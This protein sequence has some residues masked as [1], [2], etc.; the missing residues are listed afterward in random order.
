MAT[1]NTKIVRRSHALLGSPWGPG[2]A[3]TEAMATGSGPGGRLRAHALQAGLGAFMLGT[4][5]GPTRA[6]IRRLMPAPGEGPDEAARKAGHYEI[7]FVG[8]DANGKALGVATVHGD[9]DPGYGSTSRM[10][11]E[12]ALTLAQDAPEASGG[13]WTP[14]SCLGAPLLE[15]LQA[16]AGLRF[17]LRPLP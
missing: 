16:R 17:R 10:L 1:I 9:R 12:C 8:L 5:L 14:A 6:V 2:F 13:S 3:Y 4:A 7:D 11:A 15:R